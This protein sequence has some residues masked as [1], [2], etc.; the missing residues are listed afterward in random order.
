MVATFNSWCYEDGRQPGDTGIV[1]SSYGQHIMYFVGYGDTEH[2]YNSCKSAMAS[3]A[4][5]AWQD[6]LMASLTA[7]VQ[8]GMDSVGN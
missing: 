8:P 6:E 1:A 3:A 7:E 4:T 2:W 5:A